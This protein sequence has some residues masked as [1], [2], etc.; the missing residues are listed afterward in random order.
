MQHLL[1]AALRPFCYYCCERWRNEEGYDIPMSAN[2]NE[3]QPKKVVS[4]FFFRKKRFTTT[5][6]RKSREKLAEK[7]V[8][9]SASRIH[10]YFYG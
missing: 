2:V 5:F 3:T 8:H 6:S 1:L 10:F 4:A 9:P 7:P